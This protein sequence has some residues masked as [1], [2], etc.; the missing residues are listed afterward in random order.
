[1]RPVDVCL[2]APDGA[3]TS[4]FGGQAS[5]PSQEEKGD[6]TFTYMRGLTISVLFSPFLSTNSSR[7]SQGLW[8][9]LRGAACRG[10]VGVGLGSPSRQATYPQD[11]SPLSPGYPRMGPSPPRC[12]EEA[13]WW[14]MWSKVGMLRG[15]QGLG[16]AG[17]LWSQSWEA[18]RQ[19]PLPGSCCPSPAWLH[20]DLAGTEA[21]G[22]TGLSL[23]GTS[24]CW[25]DGPDG[26]A[27][28]GMVWTLRRSTRTSRKAEHQAS[29]L[30]NG[31]TS[32]QSAACQGRGGASDPI[33][34]CTVRSS[35]HATRYL[36]RLPPWS[37][38][39]RT[40]PS[41]AQDPGQLEPLDPGHDQ[42]RAD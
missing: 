29:Q 6:P 38:Q 21:G 28:R 27:H 1:M 13:R 9:L 42:T 22:M 3:H 12:P 39:P 18:P 25:K 40:S 30:Q 14:G 34:P 7:G 5:G 31:D 36:D 26:A 8:A 10:W 35:I 20:W 15:H 23:L 16:A 19:R 24:G 2:Q 4:G 41:I 11:S 33:R 32:Q 37:R 17:A